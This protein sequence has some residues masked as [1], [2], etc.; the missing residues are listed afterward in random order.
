MGDTYG[1][2]VDVWALGCLLV[3]LTTGQPLFPG[4]SNAD[5]LWL[6]L[7]TVGYTQRQLSRMKASSSLSK[8]QLPKEEDMVSLDKR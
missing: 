6:I 8:V 7:R 1:P 2:G 5:Q 4:K 3:E